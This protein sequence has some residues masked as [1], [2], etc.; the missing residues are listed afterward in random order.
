MGRLRKDTSKPRIKRTS[1]AWVWLDGDQMP[2]HQTAVQG[3]VV[4]QERR[5]RRDQRGEYGEWW[6]L[7]LVRKGEGAEPFALWV[8]E[9]QVRAHGRGLE[10]PLSPSAGTPLFD[11]VAARRRRTSHNPRR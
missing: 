5:V 3:F 8:P 4:D 11:S 1:W 2:I 6:I 10:P 7:V 9:H